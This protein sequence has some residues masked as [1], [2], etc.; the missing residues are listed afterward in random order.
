M[1]LL[2]SFDLNVKLMEA[3]LFVSLAL[4][5]IVSRSKFQAALSRR[6]PELSRRLSPMF[7]YLEVK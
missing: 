2:W 1:A 5:A 7:L 3:A 4:A 6:L